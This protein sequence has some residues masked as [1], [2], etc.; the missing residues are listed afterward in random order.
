MLTTK[1]PKGRNAMKR[2]SKDKATR[3]HNVKD[4][5]LKKET[6]AAGE[7]VTRAPDLLPLFNPCQLDNKLVSG[8]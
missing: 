5:P 8:T 7:E 3:K 1:E 2:V 4:E 6:D